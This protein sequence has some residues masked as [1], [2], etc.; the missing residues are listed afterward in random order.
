MPFEVAS[1]QLPSARSS[2]AR[3]RA[4]LLQQASQVVT[5]GT[6]QHSNLTTQE[7]EHKH[8]ERSLRSI[9]TSI[10]S[11]GL[12]DG[13]RQEVALNGKRSSRI[14]QK[15]ARSYVLPSPAPCLWLVESSTWSA[16]RR[17]AQ[18]MVPGGASAEVAIFGQFLRSPLGKI[19]TRD[20]EARHISKHL[21]RD[22][23][24]YL[25]LRSNDKR[26]LFPLASDRLLKIL[27]TEVDMTFLSMADAAVAP[28][29]I[30]PVA[31]VRP[32]AAASPLA[33]RV[34]AVNGATTGSGDGAR[35]CGRGGRHGICGIFS[36][37]RSLTAR[38]RDRLH[39]Q[40]SQ[41]C[42]LQ[43]ALG[44]F[45]L[46]TQKHSSSRV[47]DANVTRAREKRRSPLTLLHSCAG[48][49]MKK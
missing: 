5:H 22:A 15:P 3:R 8:A 36:S 12:I 21:S 24:H 39:P 48:E 30:S 19:S 14:P 10:A 11:G 47:T 28:P 2:T 29:E 40:A 46:H 13:T 9:P 7:P 1:C 4:R 38:Q 31:V 43:Q 33:H 27:P 20:S 18:A 17:S 6:A 35:R 37:A 44:T 41:Q 42:A 49:R 23:G 32:S 34:T 45:V 16:G 26:S 25:M